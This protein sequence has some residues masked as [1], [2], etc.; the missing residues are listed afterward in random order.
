[1]RRFQFHNQKCS[2]AT[3]LFNSFRQSTLSQ[4]YKQ[5][6][7][8]L[9]AMNPHLDFSEHNENSWDTGL[10]YCKLCNEPFETY[11]NH[12][13]KRDHM[14][15]ELF[16]EIICEYARDWNP[17]AVV[18]EISSMNSTRNE[19]QH[20]GLI[21]ERLRNH[22]VYSTSE[23][24]LNPLSSKQTLVKL[25]NNKKKRDQQN[26]E[27]LFRH[28]RK[29]M[30]HHKNHKI[31]LHNE[32]APFQSILKYFDRDQTERRNRVY[33][34][35]KLFV[36]RGA[37]YLG[38]K[39]WNHET[40]T[41]LNMERLGELVLF[42]WV[43]PPIQ[44]LMP[45]AVAGQISAF[46][47]Q[48]SSFYNLGSAFDFLGFCNLVDPRD[49]PN[50]IGPSFLGVD[51]GGDESPGEPKYAS[52]RLKPLHADQKQ[53][54][55]GEKPY[56]TERVKSVSAV[57]AMNNNNN[58]WS[59]PS[60]PYAAND[61]FS[62]NPTLENI[63][64]QN[65]HQQP[66]TTRYS[67]DSTVEMMYWHKG[68]VIRNILGQLRWALSDTYNP[69]QNNK[70]IGS[71]LFHE[72]PQMK[73]LAEELVHGVIQEIVFLRLAEY[74]TR[75]ESA[76][77]E[78]GCPTYSNSDFMEKFNESQKKV[79]SRTNPHAQL[80]SML[81]ASSPSENSIG[82]R[83][84]KKKSWKK[85]ASTTRN[86]AHN[87]LNEEKSIYERSALHG[88]ESGRKTSKSIDF[89]SEKAL[90]I[91]QSSCHDGVAAVLGLDLKGS[92]DF[93][94][95]GEAT[96]KLER[97]NETLFL[98]DDT[99]TQNSDP[100]FKNSRTRSV[101]AEELGNIHEAKRKLLENYDSRL[102]MIERVTRKE[103]FGDHENL[104][105]EEERGEKEEQFQKRVSVASSLIKEPT[106]QRKQGTTI[107]RTAERLFS[108]AAC[109]RKYES[110]VSDG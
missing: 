5:K 74:I 107:S 40:L 97:G 68:I 77:R 13:G 23:S 75:A 108:E 59:A 35:A 58:N 21:T 82:N 87:R 100:D 1:M 7:L 51:G 2:S 98:T 85:N 110:I 43:H 86:H 91:I 81:T 17:T 49:L 31:I 45:F 44:R 25:P 71:R 99:N 19:R 96:R 20:A 83:N 105:S 80:R 37:L 63:F 42:Q 57:D 34:I 65:N 16:Y 18:T 106:Y 4:Y 6:Q 73:I 48:C 102:R 22:F 78:L 76:W 95:A 90:E 67:S 10:N 47:Q 46:S 33:S 56:D 24:E 93:A 52:K 36:D 29:F 9:E 28:Q 79:N 8:H 84:V 88:G 39:Q 92:S 50:Y 94:S 15:I 11:N 14:T 89:L 54:F 30:T 104:V 32:F 69:L 70:K 103:M 27:E 26:E 3:T 12:R 62:S 41:E 60:S 72:E 101:V 61:S 66:T 109:G 64:S 38:P 53:Q 55:R